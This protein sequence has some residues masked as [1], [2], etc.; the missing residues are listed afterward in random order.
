MSV[1]ARDTDSVV[2]NPASLDRPGGEDSLTIKIGAYMT[3]PRYESV[4]A[5]TIIEAALRPLHINL[6]TSQGVFW[7]QCMQRMFESAVEKG[8][9]WILAVDSDSLFSAEQVSM[10]LDQFANCPR[11]AAM[12]ALQCRR[13]QP[14]PLLTDRR[15]TGIV[16]DGRPIKVTSA[17]FGL[18]LIRAEDLEAIPKPWFF[19]EPEKNGEWGDDRLDDDIWFWHQLRLA[20]KEV[21]VTPTVSIGHL[22][23]TVAVFDEHLQPKH[24]YVTEWREKNLKPSI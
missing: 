2:K 1:A 18:T 10:L 4:I 8:V 5:R 21:Y 23:E 11:A 15:N 9:D 16:T 24:Q 13:G 20:G 6:T 19:A 14:Y 12:A 22:E 17:H 3:L 7:G